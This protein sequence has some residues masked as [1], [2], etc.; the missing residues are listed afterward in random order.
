M[1][2][3]G[4][5]FV[6]IGNESQIFSRRPDV[7]MEFCG[8]GCGAQL[9]ELAHCAQDLRVPDHPAGSHHFRAP[10]TL[11]LPNCPWDLRGISGLLLLEESLLLFNGY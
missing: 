8:D 11:A 9:G 2:F 6:D 7:Q 1:T 3:A 5:L 10:A 4:R